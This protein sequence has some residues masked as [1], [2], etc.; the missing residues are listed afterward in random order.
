MECSSAHLRMYL[1]WDTP[2]DLEVCLYQVRHAY[3]HHRSSL[4]EQNINSARASCRRK[5]PAV[6]SKNP[7][8][9]FSFLLS[10][11]IQ[12]NWHLESYPGFSEREH[13]LSLELRKN[14]LQN[15]HF[16]IVALCQ[17]VSIPFDLFDMIVFILIRCWWAKFWRPGSQSLSDQKT[18]A[19]V[20]SES[21]V[22]KGIEP[23]NNADY[24]VFIKS[25]RWLCYPGIYYP[26]T[27]TIQTSNNRN[28]SKISTP[29]T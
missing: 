27:H 26:N 8:S 10:E 24:S 3:S 2:K 11:R 15:V 13:T 19:R 12:R 29:T 9:D 1:E 18:E 14:M 21:L 28:G 4:S 22:R 7:F 16:D 23:Y 25:W 5:G 6:A 20:W 17:L